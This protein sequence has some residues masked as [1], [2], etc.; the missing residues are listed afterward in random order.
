MLV[1]VAALLLG[2][3]PPAQAHATLVA[4]DPAEGAV[5]AVAPE[6]VTFTFTESVAAVPDGV[7]VFDATGDRV[8][9]EASVTDAVLTVALTEPVDDGTLVVVWRIVSADGHPVS[10]SLRFSVGAP[11]ET[12]VAPA[13]GDGDDGAARA[14]YVLRALRVTGYVCLLLATGLVAFVLL[15]LP[16]GGQTA[17]ARRRLVRVA[18]AAAAGAAGSWLLALPA[19]ATYQAGGGPDLVTRT[20]TWSALART[21]YAV[22]AFVVVGTLGA[23]ALLG[24]GEPAGLRRTTS[25][26]AAWVAIGAPALTGHSRAEAPEA[27]VVAVDVLHLLA[28]STWLGGVVALALVLPDLAGR[29]TLAAETLARFSV[30]AAGVLAVLVASGALLAWRIVG[31]WGALV[32]TDYGRLL[33]AKI[34]TAV[35]AVLLAAW[36]RRALVPRMRAA[37]RRTQVRAGARLVTKVVTAEVAILGLVLV[38]TG[39]L[40]DQSPAAAAARVAGPAVQTATLGDVSAQA[41]VSSPVTGPS[42]VTVELLDAAG[43]PTEGFAAP[44]ASLASDELDLGDLALENV[45]P[46]VYTARVVFPTAGAWDLQVSLRTSEFDNPVASVGFT[47]DDPS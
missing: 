44:T 15:V 40:V 12:V 33:L 26:A 30:I 19:V 13:I 23:V 38:L 32:G 43:E 18:R 25:L 35:V 1:V 10:G 27:L 29:G 6:R 45:G 39:L 46:G 41:T 28:G 31:S 37:T 47:V 17:R 9:A 4:S 22:A 24:A 42:E 5:L 3:A 20:A 34:A 2:T 8:A 36:N 21:E 7:Q 11:S 16:S 14:P